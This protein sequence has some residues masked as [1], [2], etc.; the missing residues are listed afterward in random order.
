[1]SPNPS[2]TVQPARPQVVSAIQA[3]GR[4]VGAEATYQVQIDLQADPKYIPDYIF[5]EKTLFVG[6]GSVKASVDFGVLPAAAIKESTDHTVVSLTLPAPALDTPSLD[7]DKSYLYTQ[8]RGVV[9]HVSDLFGGNANDT[10]ALYKLARDK[11]AEQ[12]KTGTLTDQAEQNIRAMLVALG[13]Q[14]GFAETR[15]SFVSTG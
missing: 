14:L 4:Y 2:D 13:S 1:V 7:V 8:E 5:N 10:Q 11:I 9:N 12:A 6:V 15:V 3:L